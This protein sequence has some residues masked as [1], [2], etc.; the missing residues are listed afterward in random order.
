MVK[1]VP[2]E[3]GADEKAS[4]GSG[5]GADFKPLGKRIVVPQGRDGKPL[6]IKRNPSGKERGSPQGLRPGRSPGS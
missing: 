5:L 4:F 3:D 2:E 6:T 1:T